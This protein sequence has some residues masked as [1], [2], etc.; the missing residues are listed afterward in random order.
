[1]NTTYSYKKAWVVLVGYAFLMQNF[2]VNAGND[3]GY[4]SQE[5]QS[6]GTTTVY[7]SAMETAESL[8]LAPPSEWR[9]HAKKRV[10][11][12]LLTYCP[13]DDCHL[14]ESLC[15]L[16]RKKPLEEKE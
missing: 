3:I 7:F 11:D 4:P 10:K 12:A 2:V 5:Q 6:Q 16:H 14:L 15:E 8:V 13:S 1:M 9:I